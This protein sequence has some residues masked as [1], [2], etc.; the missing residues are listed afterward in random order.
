ML[1]PFVKNSITGTQ[2][3]NTPD[4][5]VWNPMNVDGFTNGSNMYEITDLMVAD[6]KL[7]VSAYSWTPGGA[8]TGGEVR[9]AAYYTYIYT[10]NGSTFTNSNNDGFA[11]TNRYGNL[12]F[13]Q[14][15]IYQGSDNSGWGIGEL[16][17]LCTAPTPNI[18]SSASSI[19]EY[20]PVYFSD[21]LYC[22]NTKRGRVVRKVSCSRPQGT[23]YIPFGG[24]CR[25]KCV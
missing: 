21:T 18:V 24:Y 20:A 22:L 2:I 5:L 6:G 10:Y 23:I 17:R 15:F 14:N 8:L 13:Y 16:W 3:W 1:L 11:S 12:G 4:G 7:W 19:C 9:G 25:I